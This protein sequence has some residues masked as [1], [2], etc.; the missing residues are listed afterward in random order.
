MEKME[1]KKS[2]IGNS[3]VIDMAFGDIEPDSF[4]NMNK[5]RFAEIATAEELKSVS[6]RRKGCFQNI[7]LEH[8]SKVEPSGLQALIARIK[9]QQNLNERDNLLRAQVFVEQ[10]EKIDRENKALREAIAEQFEF[11]KPSANNCMGD[12]EHRDGSDVTEHRDSKNQVRLDCCGEFK[13]AVRLMEDEAQELERQS[14]RDFEVLANQSIQYLESDYARG[15]NSCAEPA[16][17]QWRQP[18]KII[19][20]SSDEVTCGK[21]ARSRE[22]CAGREFIE[23][24][25]AEA[26]RTTTSGCGESR[27]TSLVGGQEL[28]SS[29]KQHFGVGCKVVQQQGCW[30]SGRPLTTFRRVSDAQETD[31]RQKASEFR[32]LEVARSTLAS[33]RSWA[34]QSSEQLDPRRDSVSGWSESSYIEG[35]PVMTYRQVNDMQEARALM[36]VSAVSALGEGCEVSVCVR[37]DVK[38]YACEGT[39][40]SCKQGLGATPVDDNPGVLTST[41]K[42]AEEALAS[43]GHLP[44]EGRELVLLECCTGRT[45]RGPGIGQL[46]PEEWIWQGGANYFAFPVSESDVGRTFLSAAGGAHGAVGATI[47]ESCCKPAEGREQVSY[48][49][50]GAG[51]G[52]SDQ[53]AVAVHEQSSFDLPYQMARLGSV[54]L[55][56]VDHQPVEGCKADGYSGDGLDGLVIDC[57]EIIRGGRTGVCCRNAASRNADESSPGTWLLQ[58]GS[59]G[60]NTCRSEDRFDVSAGDAQRSGCD[61]IYNLNEALLSELC[62]TFLCDQSIQESSELSAFEGEWCFF[63]EEEIEDGIQHE[64]VDAVDQTERVCYHSRG[65]ASAR[66]ILFEA[67]GDF[68]PESLCTVGTAW[69]QR[70]VAERQQE[71]SCEDVTLARVFDPGGSS[72]VIVERCCRFWGADS[73]YNHALYCSKA[74]SHLTPYY[75]RKGGEGGLCCSICAA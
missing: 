38:V 27:L 29:N 19:E 47:S 36:P 74:Y 75:G 4:N 9:L 14:G 60:V 43:L 59:D 54:V 12:F 53:Y 30:H 46:E 35:V 15:S 10:A 32:A 44:A 42:G 48:R 7:V 67:M 28:D 2:K 66:A 57:V 11:C 24:S 69:I 6:S 34:T 41:S 52:T 22:P 70:L 18:D 62:C 39:G 51:L 20:W 31:A 17:N 16:V 63:E 65:V 1:H 13:R 45:E 21:I 56:E 23:C 40:F 26:L 55:R 71:D 3:G 73:L 5:Q 58:E 8:A 64:L 68:V 37:E 49:S 61:E 50:E 72:R 33:A 25:A